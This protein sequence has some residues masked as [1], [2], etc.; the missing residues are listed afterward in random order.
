MFAYDETQ[1][2]TIDMDELRVC[3]PSFK[4]L[5]P[6]DAP[7]YLTVGEATQEEAR[8][9]AQLLMCSAMILDIN[10]IW[11]S[12]MRG[13]GFH[14]SF[15]KWLRGLRYRVGIIHVDASESMC[16]ARAAKRSLTAQ[17]GVTE[18]FIAA[19]KNGVKQTWQALRDAGLVDVYLRF[20]NDEETPV[21]DFVE[22]H[23]RSLGSAMPR[24]P[25]HTSGNASCFSAGVGGALVEELLKRS[26]AIRMSH[27]LVAMEAG[28]GILSGLACFTESIVP[29]RRTLPTALQSL[30]SALHS[31][32]VLA[33]SYL[34]L[35]DI[36]RN[37]HEET[38]LM[39]FRSS[40]RALTGF[41]LGAQMLGLLSWK[42][43]V[44]EGKFQVFW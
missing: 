8:Y 3:L 32:F 41:L 33:K 9:L 37:L 2:M 4:K 19:C 7:D 13:A 42:A 11:D 22:V 27:N 10:V 35:H 12:T 26:G 38:L 24:E 40:G 28:L 14:L 36:K 23:P 21:L 18:S 1:T 16:I 30:F 34:C 5:A 44:A 31:I 15:C 20:R 25:H 39:R 43:L 6:L 29:R 17:R